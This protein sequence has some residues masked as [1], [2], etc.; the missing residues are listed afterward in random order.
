MPSMRKTPKTQ[1]EEASYTVG[2]LAKLAG[3]TVR[4]LHHYED[5]GLLHPER[6]TS[7]YRRYGATDV[8]RLQQILLLRSCGLSLGAIRDALADDRFDFRTALVDHLATLRARQK[9]LETLVGTVEK[10]IASLEGRCTM[11][12]E[13]RFE[14]M[15]ARAIAENEERYGAEVRQAYGDAAMDAA[16]ERMAGMSQE[17]WNDAKALEAAILEQLTAAKATGDPTGEAARKLC[18]MHA[19]WLQMHWGEGA[20]SP[21]AHAALAEGYVADQRFTAYYDEAAGEGATAFLRDA[22]IAWCAEQ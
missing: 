9:E 1:A 11:T 14:G 21:A 18:A 13:E 4:A 17:E 19:R 3:V 15:K 7:G 5:E 20:Y 12:D 6:S 10:T 16:N 2:S 22:L 8:E